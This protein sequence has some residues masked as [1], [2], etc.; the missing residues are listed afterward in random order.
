MDQLATPARIF[1]TQQQT[2]CRPV[3]G[4]FNTDA[5]YEKHFDQGNFNI[6]LRLLCIN[7]DINFIYDWVNQDYARRFWQMDGH[8]PTQL[9]ELYHNIAQSDFAQSFVALL[10]NNP[11]CQL[12]IYHAMRDEV[13][14]LY[15]ARRGDYGI[16]LIMAPRQKTIAGLSGYV[17]QTF[18]EY[19]FSCEEVDRII[20]EPDA[21]NQ[22]ANKLVTKLGFQFRRKINM[23]Y[24]TANL[25]TCTRTNLQTAIQQNQ[26]SANTPLCA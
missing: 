18:L 5:V 4:Q 1:N 12:D 8:T 22:G 17:L 16:H 11:V 21:E 23:S 7:T 24:K 10:N 9:K 26:Y 13:G 2:L 15:N 3:S 14:T 19:F 25:Y 20:G 6:S